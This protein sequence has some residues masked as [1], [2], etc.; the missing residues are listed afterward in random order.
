[1]VGKNRH[2]CR[3]ISLLAWGWTMAVWSHLQCCLINGS[4]AI[5][6]GE[7]PVFVGKDIDL[8]FVDKIQGFMMPAA[9]NFAGNR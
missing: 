2:F 1:M 4:P 3:H 8:Y 5:S 6:C 7:I 9:Q